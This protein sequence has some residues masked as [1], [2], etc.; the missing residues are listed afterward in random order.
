LKQLYHQIEKTAADIDST[1]SPHVQSLQ[2]KAFKRI[3][4]LEKKMLRAEKRK[5]ETEEQQLKQFKHHLFPKDSLQE[6]VDNISGWYAKYGKD[7]MDMLKLYSLSYE[8]QF[9]V[10]TIE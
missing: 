8:S 5:F 6:R 2:T 4:E 1:L 10:L 3:Q 9:S 7:W